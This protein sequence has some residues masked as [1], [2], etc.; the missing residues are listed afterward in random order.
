M[1]FGTFIVILLIA[2][3]VGAVG[4]VT[5]RRLEQG[6]GFRRR[7]SPVDDELPMDDDEFFGTAREPDPDGELDDVPTLTVPVGSELS[8][9]EPTVGEVRTVSGPDANDPDPAAGDPPEPAGP[10]PDRTAPGAT[11]PRQDAGEGESPSAPEPDPEHFTGRAE[12]YS[13]EAGRAPTEADAHP[14]AGTG[15]SA[16]ES[17]RQRVIGPAPPGEDDGEEFLTALYV[18]APQGTAFAGPAVRQAL[19]AEGLEFGAMDIYHRPPDLGNAGVI[20]SVASAVEPGTLKPDELDD[21]AVPGLALFMRL[22]G[23]EENTTAFERLLEGAQGIARRL[24]GE[25]RDERRSVL[26]NQTIQHL[27]EQVRDYGRRRALAAASNR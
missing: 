3:V 13:R 23:P 26:S 15:A 4:Y 19:E 1:S 16:G 6:D 10:A 11:G 25:L 22:P 21:Q 12:A 27:R 8:E 24:G 9:A 2:A 17:R 14:P 7:R 18:M 5:Y 20:Y